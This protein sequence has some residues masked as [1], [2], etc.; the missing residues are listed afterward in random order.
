MAFEKELPEWKEKGVKPPQSKL[1]EGWKV[2]D[3]PPAAWLNWQMNK[4]YEALKEVQEKAAETTDV[5]NALNDAREYTDQKVAGI[6]LTKITP[7]SI[8]A[9]KKAEFDVHTADKTK[10]ITVDERKAWNEAKSK[11]DNALPLTGGYVQGFLSTTG[12]MECGGFDFKLGNSDQ[13]SRGDSGTSRALVKNS[14]SVLAINFAGDFTGGVNVQGP[15]LAVD[16][17]LIVQGKDIISEIDS[18]KKSG[19][20]AKQNIVD[21]VNAQNGG[22]STADVWPTLAYKI[23]SIDSI[24]KISNMLTEVYT[25]VGTSFSKDYSVGV[26]SSTAGTTG[27]YVD[28]YHKDTKVRQFHV[29]YNR[30]GVTDSC[31]TQDGQFVFSVYLDYQSRKVMLTKH[32]I[33]GVEVFRVTCETAQC[34]GIGSVTV[35]ADASLIVVS[36]HSNN[37]N[38]GRFVVLNGNGVTI[39]DIPCDIIPSVISFVAWD[40]AADRF[41][42]CKYRD[43]RPKVGEHCVVYLDKSGTNVTLPYTEGWWHLKYQDWVH[44]DG[45]LMHRMLRK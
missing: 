35:N 31:V 39:R 19:V 36:Y 21:A 43:G 34:Y 16:N 42:A 7:D 44:S 29:T 28:V 45:F 24:K 41:Y 1:D 33:T 14:G 2:Q 5:A 6:D 40:N 32:T 10:H 18:L 15:Q 37:G 22:A 25:Y 8:G 26:L 11:A 23:R 13:I 27:L 12:N 3:K 9:V 20:D 4:T 38:S 30:E 17:R